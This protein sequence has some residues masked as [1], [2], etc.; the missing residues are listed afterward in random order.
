MA[1]TSEGTPP[2]CFLGRTCKIMFGEPMA[3][4]DPVAHQV[5]PSSSFLFSFL[6]YFFLFLVI[7]YFFLFYFLTLVR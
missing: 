6:I 1:N 3:E 7:F 2:P 5:C 4:K